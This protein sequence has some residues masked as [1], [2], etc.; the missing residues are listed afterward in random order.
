MKK[1]KQYLVDVI[2]NDELLIHK[3]GGLIGAIFGLIIGMIISD[4]AD[5]FDSYILEVED[6]PAESPK[7]E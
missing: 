7:E 6:G 3:L 1:L 4:K 2:E 5:Q